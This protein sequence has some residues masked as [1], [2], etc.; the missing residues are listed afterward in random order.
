MN[1]KM[2]HTHTAVVVSHLAGMK[3]CAGYY[4]AIKYLF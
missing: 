1:T 3:V 2:H 4:K